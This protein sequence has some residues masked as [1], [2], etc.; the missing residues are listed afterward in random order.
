MNARSCLN[1]SRL[2]WPILCATAC[3]ACASTVL[4][5][6]ASPGDVPSVTVYYGD[7]N[8]QKTEG[9]ASLYRRIQRAA[10]RVCARTNSRDLRQIQA[11]RKCTD[12]AIDRAVVS[13]N[14][15]AL[16]RYAARSKAR[17]PASAG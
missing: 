7:L 6:D 13:V 2:T 8:L 11:T 1:L 16:D 5:A 17:M 9:V 12:E 10:D 4:A 3:L 15:P 14:M